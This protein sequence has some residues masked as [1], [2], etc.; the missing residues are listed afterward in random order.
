MKK[1]GTA[2]PCKICGKAKA[3]K[4]ASVVQN[5][6]IKVTQ[7]NI[8]KPKL[9]KARGSYLVASLATIGDINRLPKPIVAVRYPAHVAV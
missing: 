2:K 6:R 9:A 4:S 3:K 1:N 8:P 7:P 5:A